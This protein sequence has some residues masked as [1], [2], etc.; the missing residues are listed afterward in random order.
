MPFGNSDD[1]GA[2]EEDGSSLFE[3]VVIM[4]RLFVFGR[5]ST[6]CEVRSDIG[7]DANTGR[8]RV[9]GRLRP[10]KEVKR[11]LIILGAILNMKRQYSY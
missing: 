3:L 11:T 5:R 8:D 10:G 4:K 1:T 2:D 9:D 7:V 6:S